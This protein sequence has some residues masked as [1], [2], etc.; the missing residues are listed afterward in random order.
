MYIFIYVYVNIINIQIF[1]IN[2]LNYLYNLK[3]NYLITKIS[4]LIDKIYLK[5]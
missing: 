5:L 1:S 4:H 3:N 2:F